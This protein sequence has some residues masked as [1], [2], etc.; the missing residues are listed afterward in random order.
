MAFNTWEGICLVEVQAE[1][2]AMARSAECSPLPHDQMGRTPFHIQ[3]TDPLGPIQ[4]VGGKSHEIHPQFL[5]VNRNFPYGLG[6]IA[7][8]AHF[9]LLCQRTSLR[10]GMENSCFVV[11]I[12]E[13]YEKNAVVQLAF[14][15]IG[16]NDPLRIDA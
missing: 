15:F 10:N 2:V 13:A 3:G 7:K 12:H 8:K 6:R 11:R 5:N 1:P 14:Q 9:S 4:F 16:F